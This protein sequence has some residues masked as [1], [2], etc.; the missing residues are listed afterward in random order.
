VS[1]DCLWS[2]WDRAL[3]WAI[4][5]AIVAVYVAPFLAAMWKQPPRARLALGATWLAAG[6]AVAAAFVGSVV[7]LD[8]GATGGLDVVAAVTAAGLVAAA[9]IR[10]RPMDAAWRHVLMSATGGITPVAL[11][12]AWIAVLIATGH[13]FD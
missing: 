4:A 6:I 9:A 11:F 10:L 12:A 13:C 5:L 2:A 8:D 7:W 3:A 1:D